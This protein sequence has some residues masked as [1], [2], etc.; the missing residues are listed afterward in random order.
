MKYRFHYAELER[1]Y[2]GPTADTATE[3]WAEKASI[4]TSS[5]PLLAGALRSLADELDPPKQVMR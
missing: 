3:G 5:K 4:E 2:S 1:S